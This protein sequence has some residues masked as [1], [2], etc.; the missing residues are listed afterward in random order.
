MKQLNDFYIFLQK[1]I[2]NEQFI[3]ISLGNNRNSG[4]EIEKITSKIVEIK[5]QK[6][7]SFTFKNKTNDIVQNIDFVQLHAFILHQIN[8]GF[9]S[10][11]L[12]SEN[13]DVSLQI[14]KKGKVLMKETAP[15][16]VLLVEGHNHT[17]NRIFESNEPFLIALGIS[18]EKGIVLP[19]A[20][21]KYLQVNQFV[22]ILKPYFEKLDIS[23]AIHVADMGSGKGYLTFGVYRYLQQINTNAIVTGVEFRQD[24]VQLCN[25]K[26]QS[27]GFEQLKF[28][29]GS[30]EETQLPQND[31]LI[32]LH[33]CDTATDDAIIK[34]IESKSSLI[35]VAPCCHKQIRREIEKNGNKS[36]LQSLY[37]HGILLEK[38]AELFTDTL[39]SLLL[40]W[41][42]YKVKVVQF[43]ADVH[44]PKNTLIIAQKGSIDNKIQQKLLTE[45]E[46]LKELFGVEKHYLQV[47]LQSF[48][49]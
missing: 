25:Q 36:K 20:K 34:G 7:V 43:N 10:A 42:G 19:H 28:V 27:L 6:K 37:K 13:A 23:K 29:K 30:I 3:S 2:D 9:A 12:W 22:E 48:Y 8:I 4:S 47:K 31:V 17:K 41:M 45:I 24:M 44:S 16:K 32:A 11:Y 38:Q 15:T 46:Q 40:E 14:S 39:R 1:V 18:N 33:A 49:S 26:A 35:V 21:E 5:G